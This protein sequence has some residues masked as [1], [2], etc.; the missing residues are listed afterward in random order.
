MARTNLIAI[1]EA[2]TR[3]V[4]KCLNALFATAILVAML[5]GL[6]AG[7]RWL[8]DYYHPL[9]WEDGPSTAAEDWEVPPE[10]PRQ[11]K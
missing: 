7:G 9:T 3:L 4:V 5:V 6:F 2:Y 10:P 8:W 1:V 11:P